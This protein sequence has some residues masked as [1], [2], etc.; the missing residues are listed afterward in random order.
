[1]QNRTDYKLESSHDVKDIVTDDV[2]V[3][4][5][6]NYLWVAIPKKDLEHWRKK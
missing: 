5:G 1:M 6:E 2:E 4:E 3:Y